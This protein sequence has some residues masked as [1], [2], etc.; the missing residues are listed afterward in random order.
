[1]SKTIFSMEVFPPKKDGNIETVYNTLDELKETKPDF[2]S[3][4]Y[5]AGGSSNCENTL[6]IARRINEVCGTESVVHLPGINMTKIQVAEV[7]AQFKEAGVKNILALRGDRVEGVP[8]GGEFNQADQLIRFIKDWDKDN[9]FKIF[10]ACYPELHPE[11]KDIFQDIRA[12][13]SKED[14]GAS[15]FLSQLFFDNE[16]YYRFVE[17]ARLAGVKS[18]LE[19]GIMPVTNKKGIERMVALTNAELPKKFTRMMDRFGDSPEAIRDAGIAYAIDQIVDLVTNGV[20][21]IHL[22]TMNNPYIAKKINEATRSLF[23]V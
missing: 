19:A 22:Y 17:R 7:L 10:A 21:G 5:G 23:Q 6:N 8:A 9:Q 13:K 1:M 4:T 12:L 15:H 14:S 11:S 18:P 20:E 2:I 3:V 16:K